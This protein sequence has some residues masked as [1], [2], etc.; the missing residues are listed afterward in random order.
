M[1][2][3][4]WEQPDHDV[5]EAFARSHPGVYGGTWSV[6][7]QTHVGLTVLRP[8][9]AMLRALLRDPGSVTIRPVRFTAAEI[10]AVR[11]EVEGLVHQSGMTW[12][13]L[14]GVPQAASADLGA[15]GV[16][17]SQQLHI[18][19]GDRVR[20]TVGGRAYPPDRAA[21][22][23]VTAPVAT[24]TIPG[25]ELRTVLSTAHVA[26]GR[27]FEGTVQLVNTGRQE[28]VSFSTDQPLVAVVVDPAG[29]V[30]GRF[31]GFIAGTGIPVDLAPGTTRDIH[32]VGGTAG[33]SGEE[34]STPPGSYTVVVPIPLRSRPFGELVTPPVPLDITP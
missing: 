15:D 21:A 18:R 32:F 19:F 16:E 6:G 28:S 5:V 8:Y 13:A 1:G 25:L 33:G 23:L 22:P 7:S 24:R 11:V 12:H 9:A 27:S 14:G 29:R 10:A 26:S 34:Y 31:S 4:A 17:L 30:A 20:L 3:S 2:R